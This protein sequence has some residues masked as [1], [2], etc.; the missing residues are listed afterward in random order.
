[1]IANDP[2]PGARVCRRELEPALRWLEEKVRSAAAVARPCQSLF[3]LSLTQSQ[4]HPQPNAVVASSP[5]LQT[6]TQPA[7]RAMRV[8]VVRLTASRDTL[9]HGAQNA[10]ANTTLSRNLT[11]IFYD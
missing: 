8:F 3:T 5:C 6:H 7:N 4:T 1:M 10:G 11:P 9:N 2:I